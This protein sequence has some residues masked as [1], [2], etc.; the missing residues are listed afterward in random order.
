MKSQFLKIA[1]VKSEKAFYK[2]FPT[3]AAFFKA[4]PEAKKLVNGGEQDKGQLKKLEQLTD[5]G[6]PPMAFDGLNIPDPFSFGKVG[7]GLNTTAPKALGDL[8]GPTAFGLRNSTDV[9]KMFGNF[10]SGKDIS[11]GIGGLTKGAGKGLGPATSYIGAATDIIGGIGA[12]KQEK[13]Q[14]K[15]LERDS[16]LTGLMLKASE[17]RP[18]PIKRQYVRP[19]D[20]IVEPNQLASAYGTGTN[21]LAAEDGATIGGNPTEIMNTFAPNTIYTNMGYEPLDD[22]SKVKQYYAGGKLTKAQL[23]G[24]FANKLAGSGFG[25]FMSNPQAG[26]FVTNVAT[27]VGGGPSGSSKLGK[28]IGTAAGTAF[29]GPVGGI[30]GGALGSLVGGL[31]GKKRKKKM[32]AYQKSID[33]NV[34]GMTGQDFS[35]GIQGEFGSFMKDGGI[36]QTGTSKGKKN[37]QLKRYSLPSDSSYYSNPYTENQPTAIYEFKDAKRTQF[38]EHPYNAYQ[39]A[40]NRSYMDF[41]GQSLASG[42]RIDYPSLTGNIY[43]GNIRTDARERGEIAAR[44]AYMRDIQGMNLYDPESLY[45]AGMRGQ[46][47]PQDTIGMTMFDRGIIEAGAKKSKKGKLEEGGWVSHTWQP[48]VITKFGEYNVDELLAPDPT[49]D[50]LRTGGHIRQN[51]IFPTDQFAMGG[52]LKVYRGEAE[53]VSVNPYLPDGGETVMF[54]GPSHENGGM[55]IE[56]GDSPVEVEGGEPA[57]K[58]KNGTSG[59]EDLVVFGNLIEPNSKRKFKNVVADI[60]KKENKENKRLDK[61]IN[62]L[63]N[64]DVD[65]PFD[66]LTL[67]S[68]KANVMG[69]N[70]KLKNYADEKMD[71]AAKQSAINETAEEFGIDAD[72]LAKGKVKK[73]NL[74]AAIKK[75][76]TGVRQDTGVKQEGSTFTYNGR[77]LDPNNPEDAVLIQ[78]FRT[79]EGKFN[80]DIEAF[81]SNAKG[82]LS[83]PI[84]MDEVVISAPNYLTFEEWLEELSPEELIPGVNE[85]QLFKQYQMYRYKY[86]IPEF[87]PINKPS[88]VK[89][90]SV[91]TPEEVEVEE[92]NKQKFP[93]IDIANEIIP[94]VRPSD[95]RGISANQILGPLAALMDNAEQ[96]V[97]AQKFTPRLVTPQNI[98]FQDRINDV[99]KQ[100]R[101]QI[102]AARGNQAAQAAI[103]TKALEAKDR[104]RAEE[105]R[106]NQANFLETQARNVDTLNKADLINLETFDKQQERQA[107][108]KSNTKATKIA[109]LQAI[110]DRYSQNRAEQRALQAYENLYNFRSTGPGGRM[111]N[112]NPLAQ[113]NIPTV[114]GQVPVYDTEGNV[115][116]F[117]Q[118]TSDK[119][120]SQVGKKIKGDAARNGSIVKAIKN[121]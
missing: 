53:P 120:A 33:Q 18:E 97:Y 14:L 57:V 43:P 71:L 26:Q 3:E 24:D 91:A 85:Q 89:T 45:K 109:A 101:A 72:A 62:M 93:W 61:S 95:A 73:A 103:M 104:I 4:H 76:Q 111:Q 118:M 22:S 6:N 114:S 99:D 80:K 13:Q 49:M 78:E 7:G 5:F 87:T 100:A 116:G 63:D 47:T 44:K 86:G 81:R 112:F 25:Q 42:R 70:M 84:G 64:L 117:Q 27:R 65:T 41:M 48:Q 17:S 52:D 11:T 113:F 19:E 94:M 106:A 108:A 51:N 1:G 82:D 107:I 32:E 77:V 54:R 10:Q 38:F 12:L 15:N 28:G 40:Y 68:L 66:K 21:I 79:A 34:F 9:S 67:D 55:P 29:L 92:K 35:Q 75:A 23:G 2:K 39:E 74:G 119:N 88:D 121:L 110:G 105:F 115:V 8:T 37:L 30:I 83:K 50:T 20:V 90:V 36:A 56:Y 16:K 31:F 59:D 46:L 98:S 60:A 96:P 102:M 58:L 69:A